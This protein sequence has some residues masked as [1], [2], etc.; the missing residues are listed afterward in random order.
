MIL[1]SNENI[2][3]ICIHS[4]S[5]PMLNVI[6]RGSWLKKNYFENTNFLKSV[7]LILIFYNVKFT[8][9]DWLMI[10]IINKKFNTDNKGKKVINGF[11]MIGFKLKYS[12]SFD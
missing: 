1:T 4:A 2:M 12:R 3:I 5:S 9:W 6:G 8:S 7:C 10:I 11:E